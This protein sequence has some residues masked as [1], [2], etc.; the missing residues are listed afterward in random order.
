MVPIAAGTY[1]NSTAWSYTFL[2]KA[3]ILSDGTTFASNATTD[4]LGWAFATAAPTTPANHA[5]T[6]PKHASQ[7]NYG[8]DFSSARSAKYATYAAMA[9]NATSNATIRTIF[10]A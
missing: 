7:G 8:M 6:L 3:C 10:R 2:C 5:S 1:T 4:V 9:S